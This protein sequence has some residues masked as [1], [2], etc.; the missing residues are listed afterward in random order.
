MALAFEIN[1]D[2]LFVNRDGYTAIDVLSDIG[3]ME[4]IFISGITIFLSLW[5]Y[6]HFDSY[7]AS[8]MYKVSGG[9][10]PETYF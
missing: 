5:N 1:L 10:G 2:L 8:Q 4:S 3:G 6:K 7:M 9:S